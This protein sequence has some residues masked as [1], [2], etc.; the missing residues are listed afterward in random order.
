MCLVAVA[1]IQHIREHSKHHTGF[2]QAEAEEAYCQKKVTGATEIAP[3]TLSS[4]ALADI[5]LLKAISI[6]PR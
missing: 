3:V 6:P 4:A 5:P 2:F 1:K